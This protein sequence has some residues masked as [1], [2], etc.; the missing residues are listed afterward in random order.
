VVSANS[1]YHSI[2]PILDFPAYHEH[3]LQVE[4]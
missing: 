2:N 4:N 1:K 3:V